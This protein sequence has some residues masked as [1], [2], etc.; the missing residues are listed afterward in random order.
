MPRVREAA[1]A[2]R[3]LIEELHR[4]GIPHQ[5][6]AAGFALALQAEPLKQLWAQVDPGAKRI[7]DRV[8]GMVR[9]GRG[10][11]DEIRESKG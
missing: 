6:I 2:A 3:G 8:I 5:E 4:E 7:L 1:A 10:L 9:E 11:V